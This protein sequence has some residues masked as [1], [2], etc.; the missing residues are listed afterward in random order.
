MVPW[1][2]ADTGFNQMPSPFCLNE[3]QNNENCELLYNAETRITFIYKSM[4]RDVVC[5]IGD[6][7]F[8]VYF[9][10]CPAGHGSQNISATIEG[11]MNLI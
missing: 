1:Q 3:L 6:S 8:I 5:I 11:K 9:G 7:I 10:K 2:K 4:E